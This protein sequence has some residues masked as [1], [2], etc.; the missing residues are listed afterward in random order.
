MR[1]GLAD[2]FFDALAI[3]DLCDLKNLA[4]VT[5]QKYKMSFQNFS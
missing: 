2:F 1:S 4:T 3:S 5:A